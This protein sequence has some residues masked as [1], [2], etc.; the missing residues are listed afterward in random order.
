MPCQSASDCPIAWSC[1]RGRCWQRA[2]APRS[3]AG[4]SDAQVAQSSVEPVSDEDAGHACAA[5][6]CSCLPGETKPCYSGALE[7]L[8]RGR[9]RPGRSICEDG[10]FGACRDE[11]LPAAESCANLGVDDDC[12]G[13]V[14]ERLDVGEPCELSDRV[15]V[16]ASGVLQCQDASSVPVCVAQDPVAESCN[17]LDDDCD[18]HVDEAFVLSEDVHNCGSC[19]AA[20]AS[21]QLCCDGQCLEPEPC[22]GA[23]DTPGVIQ[24]DGSCSRP[25]PQDLD[26]ECGRCGGVIQCDGSCSVPE[27]PD[28][29]E[30]C[31][32]GISKIGCS[33]SCECERRCRSGQIIPCAS[34]CPFLCI[35]SIC[36]EL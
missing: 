26:Q 30:R 21:D 10:R 31:N 36:F 23:C 34:L 3:D 8:G 4:G 19:G 7:T 13:K 14:D 24:C 15:G 28:Y 17:G 20:C 16:C 5:D 25:D 18:G 33:G 32:D 29:G 11:R 6:S 35:G 22:G 27:P 9:C 2:A 1:E 12:D